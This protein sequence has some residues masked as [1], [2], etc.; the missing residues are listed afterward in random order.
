[1][2]IN[3]LRIHHEFILLTTRIGNPIM[4]HTRI[5]MIDNNRPING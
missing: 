2:G 3:G 5:V 1:M 4:V